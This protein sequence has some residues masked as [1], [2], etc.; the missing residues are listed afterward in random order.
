LKWPLL[1]PRS[2]G[3]VVLGSQDAED[4]N[5]LRSGSVSTS[6]SSNHTVGTHAQATRAVP[7]ADTAHVF[8]ADGANGFN[9]SGPHDAAT[10]T[11]DILIAVTTSISAVVALVAMMNLIKRILSARPT[12]TIQVPVPVPAPADGR[13][14]EAH[15]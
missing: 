3:R 9:G 7:N 10:Q 5:V 1:F 2:E 4:E 14:S 11:D 8:V 12:A 13:I 15:C 6:R